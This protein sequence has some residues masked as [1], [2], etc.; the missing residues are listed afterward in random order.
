MSPQET[1]QYLLRDLDRWAFG[2]LLAH[3]AKWTLPDP[4]SI[5]GAVRR[6]RLAILQ[7]V[8]MAAGPEHLPLAEAMQG[9]RLLHPDQHAPYGEAMD[10]WETALAGRFLQ[11]LK[12][13]AP[14]A[15]AELPLTRFAHGQY[16]KY[17]RR[18]AFLL[19]LPYVL[20][21]L[22]APAPVTA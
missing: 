22:Y 7:A 4:D 12:A 6:Y 3:R 13:M 5:D 2:P 15:E 9:E 17:S 8:L 19:K 20:P 10:T 14:L 11:D 21:C 18:V 16:F 1:A